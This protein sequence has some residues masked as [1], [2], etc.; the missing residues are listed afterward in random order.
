M[1]L[2]PAGPQKDARPHFFN[3][4]LDGPGVQEAS[5]FFG[6][7]IATKHE[8]T[9]HIGFQNIVGFP[10]DKSKVKEQF[11]RTGIS[12]WSFDIF[13]LAEMNTDWRCMP[14]DHKL[15][16]RTKGW[17]DTLHIST[18][19]NITTTATNPKW[20]GGTALFSINKAAHRAVDKGADPT[21]LGRWCWTR[22]QGRNGHTLCILS[23]YRPNPPNGP[24]TVYAHQPSFQ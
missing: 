20:F 12:T 6:D 17:R 9:L 23:A 7:S 16:N 21:N 14:E 13:G 2:N 10:L 24:F 8:N 18:V 5:D 22:F 1:V 3:K 15:Y 4:G 19:F 11:I